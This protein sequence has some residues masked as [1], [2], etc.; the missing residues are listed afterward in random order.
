MALGQQLE[1]I[2]VAPE[3]W[4]VTLI[5]LLPYAIPVVLVIYLMDLYER[6][7]SASS[8]RRSCGAGSLRPPS[9]STRTRRWR[10]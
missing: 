5:L 1:M 3:A 8:A 4:F 10:S 2:Q 7:R 9:R 6:S